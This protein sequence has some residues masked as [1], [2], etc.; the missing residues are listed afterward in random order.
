MDQR[1]ETRI[2][3]QVASELML[4]DPELSVRLKAVGSVLRDRLKDWSPP[5]MVDADDEGIIMDDEKAAVVPKKKARGRKD[6]AAPRVTAA[7][8]QER[9]PKKARCEAG[10]IQEAE[11]SPKSLALICYICDT[12]LKDDSEVI[13]QGQKG[14]ETVFHTA[15]FSAMSY[16][17]RTAD[18]LDEASS[19]KSPEGNNLG[20]NAKA[21]QGMK[22]S[23]IQAYKSKVF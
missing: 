12:M 9:N 10:G 6:P 8:L 21:L 7:S 4:E 14:Y 13:I 20:L 3:A 23:N 18:A 1:P 2:R 5:A 15:C 22:S 17:H 16:I 19:E 11:L